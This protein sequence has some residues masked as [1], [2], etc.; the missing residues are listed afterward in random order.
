MDSE[1][2]RCD[3]LRRQKFATFMS[4]CVVAQT[5]LRTCSIGVIPTIIGAGVYVALHSY[6]SGQRLILMRSS[7]KGQ[8]LPLVF[9]VSLVTSLIILIFTIF[10]WPMVELLTPFLLLPMQ[11]VLWLT[12]LVVVIWSVAHFYWNIHRWR[13]AS[14][15][16]LVCIVL[17]GIVTLVPITQ[18]WIR[19]NFVANKAVRE[20]IVRK[21]FDGTLRPNVAHNSSLIALPADDSQVSMGGN[22]IVVEKHDGITYVFFFT[23][24]GILDNYAGFIHVPD[25]GNPAL[26]DDLDEAD[27]TELVPFDEHWFYVSHH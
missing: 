19:Y 12:Y 24:R 22:E 11:G 10:Q 14:L 3:L 16:L 27:R 15:P 25:G 21:V 20:D 17:F 8:A 2:D 7:M 18:L 4:E 13:V 1:F 6:S 9:W 5:N 23:F 26:F